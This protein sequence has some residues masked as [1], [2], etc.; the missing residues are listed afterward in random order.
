MFD[1]LRKFG[2]VLNL[3]KCVSGLP[4]LKFLGHLVDSNG[5]HPLPSKVATIRDF[6]APTSKRQL[7]RFLSMVNFPRRFFPHSTDTIRQLTII[8]SGLKR[9]LALSADAL[10][11]FDKVKA[12]L[13]EATLLT[14]F[15]PDAPISV[16]STSDKLNPRKI[17]Q[18]HYISQCTSDMRHIDE[19]SNEVADAQSRPSIVH[20]QS[21][22]GIGLAEGAVKKRPVVFACDE[23]VS[24]LR[25][26]DLPLTTGNG[27]IPCDTFTTSRRPFV[28]PFL[29]HKA[30]SFLQNL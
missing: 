11:A 9:S 15:P 28:L 8:L 2:V 30:F 4:S 24:G 25:L 26:Q 27:T 12:T 22:L 19:P 10:T 13:T 7:R 29:H 14:H 5:I 21:S 1:R 16:M 17:H 23:D 6:L 3:S 18:L 20:L